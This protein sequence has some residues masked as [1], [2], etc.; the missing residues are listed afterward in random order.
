M[1]AKVDLR[2]LRRLWPIV[3][4]HKWVLIGAVSLTPVGAGFNLLWPLV[5]KFIIDDCIL[6]KRARLLLLACG[7]TVGLL[8][9]GQL[10][11]FAS[12]YLTSLFTNRFMFQLRRRLFSKLQDLDVG[13]FVKRSKGDLL[14][15][16]NSDVGSVRTLVST[17]AMSILSQVG[18]VIGTVGVAFALDWRITLAAMAATPFYLIVSVKSRHVFRSLGTKS[19]SQA[20]LLMSFLDEALSSMRLTKGL[21][22]EDEQMRRY[23]IAARAHDRSD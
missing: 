20:G 11:S 2:N 22:R 3:R 5:T 21:A 18:T 7:F 19:R 4:S 12:G 15:R 9:I 14:S 23:D 10:T 6:A 17:P 1:I 8:A 16:L 13:Y